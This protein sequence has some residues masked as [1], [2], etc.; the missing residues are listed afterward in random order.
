MTT[1]IADILIVDDMPSNLKVLMALL[2]KAGYKVRP[3]A[4]GDM[5]IT[6]ARTAA[7]DLVLLD[8]NMPTMNGYEVCAIFKAD[9]K[10]AHIPVILITAL[11][12][13]LDKDCAKAVGAVDTILKPFRLDDVLKKIKYHLGQT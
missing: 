5:A 6:A 4:S 12:A 7:P 3:A 11:G 2:N 9:E 8:I 1:P 10:L 13:E